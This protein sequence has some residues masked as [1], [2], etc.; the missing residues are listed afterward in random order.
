M[1]VHINGSINKLNQETLNSKFK[2][3][4][5][6]YL[7]SDEFRNSNW[8][9]IFKK[10]LETCSS[11]V[12]IGYSLY[13]I[14]IE[15]ILYNNPS[16]KNKVIFIQKEVDDS[17]DTTREDYSFNKYGKLYRIGLSGFCSLIER[18]YNEISNYS[19]E[20]YTEAFS[21]YEILDAPKETIRE[22]DIESFLKHGE[23]LQEYI[24]EGMTSSQAVPF[25]INRDHK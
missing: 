25:L 14:E 2:L 10:D 9:Y 19:E 16:F 20:F 8:S 23:L 3:T 15:K 24:Q 4:H 13:D 1:C 11:I 12:F 6:S 5:S 18:Q 17:I 7:T 21:K 22:K